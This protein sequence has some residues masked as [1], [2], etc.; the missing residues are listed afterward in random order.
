MIYNATL[1]YHGK[2]CNSCKMYTIFLVVGFLIIIGISSA[3]M[4]FHWYL[5]ISSVS[6]VTSVHPKIESIIY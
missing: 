6:A 2:I 5:K 3:F 4:C 1:N